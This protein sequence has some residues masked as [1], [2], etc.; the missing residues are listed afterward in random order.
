MAT[1]ANFTNQY[2]VQ[3]T[4]RFEL[5]PQGKTQEHIDK[6]GFIKDDE[7][8][9]KDYHSIKKIIDDLHKTFIEKTLEQVEFDWTKLAAAIFDYRKNKND[10]TKKT[11]NKEQERARKE[12]IGWFEGKKGNK[13]FQEEQKDFFSKIFK[14]ELF[15]D[16]LKKDELNLNED[17]KNVI[18]TFDK[19][20]TYFNGFH[21]NRKNMYSSEAKSTSIA[22]RLVNENFSKFLSNCEAYAVL[23]EIC[24]ELLVEAEQELKSHEAYND[25]NL[26]EIFTINGFN[27]FL[28]QTNIDYY[29]QLIGGITKTEGTRKI[30]GINEIINNAIQQNLDL[31]S[32]LKNKQCN[33]VQI[34]KQ[35]LSDKNTFSFV[36]EQFKEDQDVI[37][38]VIGFNDEINQNNTLEAIRNIFTDINKYDKTKIYIASKEL[39]NVS[40]SL[41]G[42]WSKIREIILNAK[43]TNFGDELSKTK[44]ETIEREV[45]NKDFS[46]AELSIYN[47]QF[48]RTNKDTNQIEEMPIEKIGEEIIKATDDVIEKAN[49]LKIFEINDKSKNDEKQSINFSGNRK[50]REAAA[51]FGVSAN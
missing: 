14:K 34:F 42:Q 33:M 30:R 25:I 9:N 17:T 8:R 49:E 20:T 21:E 27:K 22:Y 7:Q 18:E 48:L 45:K 39:S 38:A 5:I 31:K 26:A 23:K 24:P 37:D 15:S 41:L 3:K 13:E 11:L 1:F 16:L 29:N 47:D 19:F 40:M 12:I 35:I 28:N 10:T 6:K 36:A 50:S 44:K 51:S 32:A 4:L 43:L 46:V 2:S